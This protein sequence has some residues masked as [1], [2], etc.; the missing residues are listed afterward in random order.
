MKG[1]REMQRNDYCVYNQTNECFLSLG[2]TLGDRPFA[3]FKQWLGIG[4][5]RVDEGCWI[6]PYEHRPISFL[7]KRDLVYLDVKHRVLHVIESYPMLHSVPVRLDATSLLALPEHSLSSSQTRAGNQ[8]LICAAEEM[9]RRLR[10]L[11]QDHPHQAQAPACQPRP[12]QPVEDRS[13]QEKPAIRSAVDLGAAVS[14]QPRRTPHQLASPVA[15][16]AEGGTL[17]VHAIRDLS[18]T[19]LYLVTHD[20]WPIGAEVKM[21]LQPSGGLNDKTAGPITV[22]MRV[23]RWGVDGVGLEFAGAAAE[24][25]ELKSLYVC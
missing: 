7:A 6:R 4:S 11:F 19:G 17:A 1:G 9:Q 12:D 3:R 24:A 16:Y 23:T 20:R 21:S 13:V 10:K 22:R 2:A 25:S 18:A 5:R 15:Y 8:L 14:A